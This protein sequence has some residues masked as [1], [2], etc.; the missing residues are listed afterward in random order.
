VREEKLDKHLDFEEGTR[1]TSSDSLS[2]KQFDMPLNFKN[3]PKTVRSLVAKYGLYNSV[4]VNKG[5]GEV[6]WTKEAIYKNKNQ[7][8]NNS[9]LRSVKEIYNKEGEGTPVHASFY[10]EGVALFKNNMEADEMEETETING[11]LFFEKNY[12][13]TIDALF[14]LKK[15]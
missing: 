11:A 15:D 10:H 9:R 4:D 2:L 7:V 13:Y 12:L 5:R 8:S 6:S 14:V 1:V 3:L